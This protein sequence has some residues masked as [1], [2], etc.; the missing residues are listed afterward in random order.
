MKRLIALTMCAV[1]LGAAAQFPNLP[2]NPDENGDGLIGV[3]DLQGLLSNYGSEFSSAVTS[4]GVALIRLEDEGRIEC[5]TNCED[6]PGP[7]SSIDLETAEK[8][9]DLL[10]Q[11]V[12]ASAQYNSG[13]QN[14]FWSD[15]ATSQ[16]AAKYF[17]GDEEQA[18][19]SIISY[20][21]KAA[22]ICF[23]KERPKIEWSYCEHYGTSY[24]DA[25]PSKIEECYNQK[26]EGGWYPLGG[27][28]V[29][30]LSISQSFWRWAE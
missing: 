24:D 19:W 12:A 21:D 1:S 11:L 2:Y 13:P 18:R 15:G 5:S 6:L 27:P 22:C 7:W 30:Q 29:G 28:S 8:H 26:L 16:S 14:Y 3:T 9:F 17:T 4:D 20:Y 23:I 10:Q 25:L